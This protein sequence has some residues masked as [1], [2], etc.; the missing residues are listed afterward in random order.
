MRLLRPRA[1]RT[2]R[3]PPTS[4]VAGSFVL[5]V[6][7]P[8]FAVLWVRAGP[9]A[10]SVP[11]KFGLGLVPAGLSYVMLVVPAVQPGKC[12]PLWL[13]GGFAVITVG[14]ILLSPVGLSVTT[15]LAPAAFVTQMMGLWPAP[16]AAAQ[17][18]SAQVVQLYDRAHAAGYFA[19]VGGAGV[20]VGLLLLAGAP[21]IRRHTG[22][23]A[24]GEASED[25]A[26]GVA[27][28][29]D[30]AAPRHRPP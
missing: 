28:S 25:A 21:L 30:G 22:D 1:R 19:A 27:A 16:N 7:R 2:P 4:A 3:T 15:Q 5:I 14:E 13:F 24:S 8:L 10:P 12:N 6:L 17:G 11:V 23:A 29:G 9:R 20:L 18:I 26:A